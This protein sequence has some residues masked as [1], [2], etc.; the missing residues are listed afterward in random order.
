MIIITGG[1]GFIGSSIAWELNKLGH[2]DIILVDNLRNGV[3]WKNLRALKY[4]DY[5]EKEVFFELIKDNKF[6]YP[7]SKIIHM[8]ACSSPAQNDATYLVKNNYEFTKFLADYSIE[9][10]IRFIY[11]SSAATYGEGENEFIDN[12]ENLDILRPLNMYGY[13][14]QMFD[15]YAKRKGYFNKIIGLKF[16]NVFGPN[17]YHKDDMTSKVFKAFNE[18]NETGRIKLFKSAV[19]GWKDGESV[20]DFIYI[21]DVVKIVTSF[22]DKDIIVNGLFNVGTGLSRSWN[23]LANAV[24]KNMGKGE[25]EYIDMP[26][27]LVDK[28][29]YYTESNNK[30]L[31][32]VL[33]NDIKFTSLEDSIED[34]VK[35]YL[36]QNKHLGD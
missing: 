2:E 35:N 22:A 21:K 20:R 4:V 14:K 33:G 30:K 5:F 18:I 7:I 31:L 12:E 23:N 11:A 8:G 24:I 32:S 6:P 3:K 29:Q 17:E 13:S 16:F 27:Q 10:G 19:K 1:A 36:L 25:I 26:K 28:Y 9:N 15:L 34:Y